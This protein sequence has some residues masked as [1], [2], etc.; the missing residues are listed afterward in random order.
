MIKILI[1]DMFESQ[2]RTLVNTV[3]CVGI[4]GKGIAKEFKKRFPEMFRDYAGRCASKSVLPGVP[5]LYTDLL[6][7]S[8][9]NFPTK[10]HWR[11]P[12]KLEDV[13]RG[14]DI[15]AE[16][17]REW[18]VKSVAFPPLGCGS[19][20]LEWRTVG[21]IMYQ[22]LSELDLEVEIYAPFGT[23]RKELSI[24]FLEQQ[25]TA[26]AN[27]K[28]AVQSKMKKEWV[29]LL[30]VLWQLERQPYAAPVGRTIF[31]KICYVVTEQEIDTDFHFS[32]GSYGPFAPE[33]KEALSVF[34]NANLAQEQLLGR[35]TALRT[36][37]DY[38][39]LREKYADYLKSVRRVVTKT[40]D[41]FCRIKDTEQAEE[42]ATVFYAARQVKA[43]KPHATE[44]DIFNYIA[45]WKKQWNTPQK[46]EAV[47]SAIRHLVMLKWVGAEFSQSLPVEEDIF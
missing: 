26:P 19:G 33:I 44:Q 10:D 35:M 9:I 37:P 34:A 47:A 32:Q 25:A 24:E 28:G 36:G 21:P 43:G 5:Y 42:V 3:N 8:I 2:A 40:V 29:P 13:V 30:E 4:M 14:L 17:Y 23:P 20:G 31:Q 12:S 6:G 15:F 7:N 18:G 45:E 11:S 22:R 27:T 1:G 46:R 38:E 41:L 39:A 16:K